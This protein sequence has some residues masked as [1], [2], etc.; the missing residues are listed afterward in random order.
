MQIPSSSVRED[1]ILPGSADYNKFYVC[2]IYDML[3]YSQNYYDLIGA[4]FICIF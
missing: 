2:V 4:I 3:I 1:S